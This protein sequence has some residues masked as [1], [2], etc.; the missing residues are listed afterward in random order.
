VL[1]K[2]EKNFMFEPIAVD[3]EWVRL[4]GHRIPS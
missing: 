3:G 1:S 4:V 2:Y